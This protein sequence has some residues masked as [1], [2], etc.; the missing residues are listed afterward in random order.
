MEQNACIEHL[1]G[2]FTEELA[3]AL[4]SAILSLTLT[5]T[6]KLKKNEEQ[7]LR[8]MI[9]FAVNKEEE[10]TAQDHVTEET[11]IKI[12][13]AGEAP[14]TGSKP[15]LL[16]SLTPRRWRAGP[17]TQGAD[18]SRPP[19]PES[20]SPSPESPLH[21]STRARHGV[22]LLGAAENQDWRVIGQAPVQE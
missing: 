19:R 17:P 11:M 15:L 2:S 18:P 14:P 22:T 6:S 5:A 3:S 10:I 8:R 13:Q 12:P 20:S 16:E 4:S 9:G 7:L 1:W 21:R